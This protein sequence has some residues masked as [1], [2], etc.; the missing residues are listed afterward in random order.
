MNFVGFESLEFKFHDIGEIVVF[1]E[2][3]QNLLVTLFVLNSAGFQP[4]KDGFGNEISEYFSVDGSGGQKALHKVVIVIFQFL[5]HGE[6]FLNKFLD[7]LILEATAFLQWFP[8]LLILEIISECFEDVLVNIFFV[9]LLF[10]QSIFSIL[11]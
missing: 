9:S 2:L 6:E 4:F 5:F 10:F 7:L 11:S 3:D 1:L 8:I